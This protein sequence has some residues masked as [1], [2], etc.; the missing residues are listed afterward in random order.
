MAAAGYMFMDIRAALVEVQSKTEQELEMETAYK[1]AARAVACYRLFAEGHDL[2][3]L[4]AARDYEHEASEHAALVRDGAVTLLRIE[5]VL[6]EE[7]AGVL[8]RR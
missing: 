6:A 2:K 8:V 5:E 3:W 4:A 7:C 1:W